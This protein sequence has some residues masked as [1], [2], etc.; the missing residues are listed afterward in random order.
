MFKTQIGHTAIETID[1]MADQNI[2]NSPNGH[3]IEY[4]FEICALNC[5]K[6]AMNSLFYSILP[7]PIDL[8]HI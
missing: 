8:S 3:T 7:F 5:F 2:L 1:S 6:T 4:E